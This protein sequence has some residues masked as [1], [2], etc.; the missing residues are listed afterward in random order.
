MGRPGRHRRHDL[1][2]LGRLAAAG[3]LPAP[4]QLRSLQ[5]DAGAR[6]RT[7]VGGCLP[8]T[9]AG[10]TLQITTDAQLASLGLTVVRT[11][12]R[13]TPSSSTAP[14]RT[15]P[16]PVAGVPPG[17]QG[18]RPLTRARSPPTGRRSPGRRERASDRNGLLHHHPRRL[19]PP[20]ARSRPNPG[21]VARVRSR[22]GPSDAAV[23]GSG[24][25]RRRIRR[26]VRT[27]GS[28]SGPVERTPRPSGVGRQRRGP[29]ARGS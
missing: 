1:A 25:T 6:S 9:W 17:Q 16:S 22:P 18:R 27:S 4:P 8:A 28:R 13:A 12:D 2:G 23:H 14:T 3:R 21:H 19:I 24:R 26:P 20:R 11:A 5:P 10:A 7:I 29:A 15:S